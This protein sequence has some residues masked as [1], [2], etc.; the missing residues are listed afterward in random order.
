MPRHSNSH[1]LP[2]QCLQGGY[3]AKVSLLLPDSEPWQTEPR[4]SPGA[5]GWRRNG[6]GPRPRLQGGKGAR[7]RRRRWHRT[8]PGRDFVRPLTTDPETPIEDTR[9]DGDREA[10]ARWRSPPLLGS[11]N[12]TVVDEAEEAPADLNSKGSAG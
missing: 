4:V 3:D 12:H 1:G 7:R 10:E 6:Q 2:K 8:Q 11:E 5:R 9:R